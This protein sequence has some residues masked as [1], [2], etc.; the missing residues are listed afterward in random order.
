MG[1]SKADLL[2]KIEKASHELNLF[3]KQDFINY[4]GKTSDTEELYSEVVAE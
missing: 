1:Y 2:D 4:R 3:Y